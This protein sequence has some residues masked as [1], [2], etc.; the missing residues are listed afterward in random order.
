MGLLFINYDKDAPLDVPVG[1]EDRTGNWH[2]QQTEVRREA[3]G[4]EGRT[5]WEQGR[6]THR[7]K[8]SAASVAS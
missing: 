1:D 2:E 4:K 6:Q 7:D 8:E 3:E 5:E